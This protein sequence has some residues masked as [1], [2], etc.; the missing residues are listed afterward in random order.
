MFKIAAIGGFAEKYV[1]RCLQ[2]F[3]DQTFSEWE[4]QV[5]VDPTGDKTYENALP[6]ASDK[7]RV[8]LNETRQYA[9]KNVVDAI[10][11]LKP[12][13][14]DIIIPMDL[15]DWLAHKNVLEIVNG[16]YLADP[17]L[18]LTYGS[19]IAFPNPK[20]RTN[21]GAY[22][23][24]DFQGN[25]RKV[26]WK[27][28][29]LKTYK[30]KLWKHV[31]DIDLRDVRG[32]YYKVT[33]D[34]AM[35]WPMLEMAGFNRIQFIPDILY[36]YNKESEYSDDKIHLREQMYITDYLASKKPYA[37]KETL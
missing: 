7:I 20:E 27:C 17:K 16:K 35:I 19:W 33:W 10:A 28:T 37:Y 31:Q 34:L 8:K 18:L 1:D 11:L 30:Y 32:N 3:M 9:L 26:R 29:S 12:A 25:L 15:D 13:D 24:E 21:N 6:L 5:I 2:S 14:D 36:I 23:A 22:T 4:M